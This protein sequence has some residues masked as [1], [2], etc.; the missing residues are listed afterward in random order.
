MDAQPGLKETLAEYRALRDARAQ[1]LEHHLEAHPGLELKLAT[2]AARL[3]GFGSQKLSDA[4][5]D[6]CS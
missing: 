3:R 1:W 5:D 4:A 6:A 2:A